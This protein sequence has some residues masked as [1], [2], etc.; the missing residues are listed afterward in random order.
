MNQKQHKNNSKNIKD[1]IYRGLTK[2][3]YYTLTTSVTA[4]LLHIQLQRYSTLNNL[5][6]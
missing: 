2:T 3:G 6:K 4:T 5:L 1:M